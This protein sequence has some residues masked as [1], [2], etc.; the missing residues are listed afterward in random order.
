MLCTVQKVS[1]PTDYSRSYQQH[2]RALYKSHILHL[3]TSRHYVNR[4]KVRNHYV[5]RIAL[6]CVVI[7]I[8]TV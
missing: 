8:R 5:N 2:F 1:T 3:S 7:C 4:K 6:H